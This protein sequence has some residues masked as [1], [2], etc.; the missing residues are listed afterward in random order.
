MAR[1]EMRFV[2][3]IENSEHPASL[4]ARKIYEVIRDPQAERTQHIRVID[5]SGEDYLY[6][7][8]YFLPVEL[9]PRVREALR[10]VP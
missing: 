10:R 1:T 8:A 2:V 3:C 5:E 7:E 4:E 9:P 6:P